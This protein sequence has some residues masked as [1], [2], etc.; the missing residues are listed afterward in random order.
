MSNS[1]NRP[2]DLSLWAKVMDAPKDEKWKWG[3][4]IWAP[5]VDRIFRGESLGD[6]ECPVCG[7]KTLYACFVATDLDI[8]DSLAEHRRVYVAERWFGCDHCQ[9]QMRDWG[10][11]PRWVKDEDVK[12]GTE[13]HSIHAEEKLAKSGFD[14]S[15]DEDRA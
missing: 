11:I 8:P 14:R 13:W 5:V 7:N 4:D 12:W 2:I 3:W 10:Q 1:T 15:R 6:L 9:T